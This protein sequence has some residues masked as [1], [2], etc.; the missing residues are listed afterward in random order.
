[1]VWRFDRLSWTASRFLQIV[2]ELHRLGIDFVSHEQ[3]LDTTTAMGKVVLAM[4]AALAELERK[5]FQE[6]IIA[7]LEH[8]RIHGTKSGLPIGRP[9]R[10]FDRAR[11]LELR[12]QGLSWRHI[13]RR[14]GIPVETARRAFQAL[15]EAAQPCHDPIA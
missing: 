4:F 12:R 14:T 1:M 6:R 7:G 10:V 3:S 15:S 11:V 5:G 8:A 13:A 9:K 2:E